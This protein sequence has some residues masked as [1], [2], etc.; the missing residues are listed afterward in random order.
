MKIFVRTLAGNSI[1]VMLREEGAFVWELQDSIYES[2][3]IPPSQQRLILGEKMLYSTFLLSDYGIQNKS[4]LYL[5]RS[6]D[7]EQI[8]GWANFAEALAVVKVLRDARTKKKLVLKTMKFAK[9][10]CIRSR[11]IDAGFRSDFRS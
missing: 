10:R 6:I 3:N 9:R 2:T 1:T 5:V 7:D 8:D 11:S 4:T